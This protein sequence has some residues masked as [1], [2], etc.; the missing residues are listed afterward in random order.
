MGVL[1]YIYSKWSN[2]LIQTTYLLNTPVNVGAGRSD[3]VIVF[4][5]EKAVKC[6]LKLVSSK[7]QKLS[8]II[9]VSATK[10]GENTRNILNKL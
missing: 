8:K 9:F 1:F 6:I 5:A 2:D 4:L 3:A 7:H 10:L